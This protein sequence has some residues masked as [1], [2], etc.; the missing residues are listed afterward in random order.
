MQDTDLIYSILLSWRSY[1]TPKAKKE[2]GKEKET[3][4]GN[5]DRMWLTLEEK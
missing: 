4:G 2:M 1:I 3:W 5:V